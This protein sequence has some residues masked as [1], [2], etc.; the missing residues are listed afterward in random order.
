[1]R[2][3][4]TRLTVLSALLCKLSEVGGGLASKPPLHC[5]PVL[6][7]KRYDG[8]YCWMNQ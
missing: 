1:M 8:K 2:P 3:N 4:M 5:I 6:A 7:P